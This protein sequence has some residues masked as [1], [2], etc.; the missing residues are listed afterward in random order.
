M[1]KVKKFH[2]NDSKSETYEA[3]LE[4]NPLVRAK[5]AFQD[6]QTLILFYEELELVKVR[7]PLCQ[8]SGNFKSIP[9]SCSTCNGNG[10]IEEPRV[11]VPGFQSR[12]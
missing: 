1:V 10:F 6:K 12:K 3:W 9:R 11:K 8:G 4:R 2:L 5:P 7:C